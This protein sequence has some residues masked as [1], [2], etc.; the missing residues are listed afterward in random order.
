MFS[1]WLKLFHH[2]CCVQCRT[3]H[4]QPVV[5]TVRAL[6]SVNALNVKAVAEVQ[7]DGEASW[8]RNDVPTGQGLVFWTGVSGTGQVSFRLTK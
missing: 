3:H 1:F 6:L 5:H 2:F 4:L 7:R 8:C